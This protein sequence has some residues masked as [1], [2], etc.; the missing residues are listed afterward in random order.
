MEAALQHFPVI[1]GCD[2]YSHKIQGVTY[3]KESWSTV[4]LV[5]GDFSDAYTQS[6]L[7]DLE[8]SI[9][10]LGEF[11]GWE[12]PKMTLATKLARLVFENCF[13]ETPDG[14]M[15]QRQG[16]PMGGHSS[17]EGLDDI[18]L[19]C[20]LVL[21]NT[22][23]ADK[24]MYFYRM[25]DDISTA[26]NGNFSFVRKLVH[27]FSDVYPTAMPL[28]I[29]ISFGYSR[30]LDSHVLNLLQEGPD[31][32]LTTTMAYKPLARFNY[33][34]F[35]SNI[36][37]QYK[38]NIEINFPQWVLHFHFLKGSVVPSFLHRAHHRCTDQ[39]DRDHHSAFLHNVLRHRNQNM[40]VI[41]QKFKV[42]M[43]KLRKPQSR[44]AS[45]SRLPHSRVLSLKF[46]LTSGLHLFT[47][48]CVLSAYK[49]AGITRPRLIYSSLPKVMSRIIT[50]RSLLRKVK[51]YKTKI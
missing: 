21:L 16:F 28:N 36:S 37:P 5:S 45:T 8:Q 27:K 51:L 41:K 3:S 18:L 48:S 29:Q 1:Y 42:F 35:N 23:I 47:R 2:E 10:K 26:V 11:V 39:R 50:K 40:E 17:R 4:T 24:L 34:P 6:R 31:N 15:Q 44:K 25:V 19:S 46:D 49:S 7:V 33:V 14:I 38:G 9:Q 22:P 20:E 32:K 13:F 43:R 12:L 30:F